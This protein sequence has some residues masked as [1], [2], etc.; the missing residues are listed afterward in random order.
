MLRIRVGGLTILGAPRVNEPAVGLFVGPDGFQ[1]WDDST[2]GR[3]DSTDRPS[4]H[5]S[6]DGPLLRGER[7]FSVDGHAIAASA[8][9]LGHLRSRVTGLGGDG[10]RVRVTVDH[11]GQTLWAD[12]KVPEATF[13]DLGFRGR[14]HRARFSLQFVAAD[15]RK[16]GPVQSFPGAS[17]QAFHYGNFPAAPVIDVVG[18]VAAPY[19]VASQ[20]KSYT[21][22]QALTA[23]QTHRIDMSTGW[24]TRN[25]VLQVGVV[26][27]AQTFEIPPGLPVT[28][29]GPASMTVKVTDTYI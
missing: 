9:E 18:P 29:T 24:V 22:T 15:M 23:G 8:A 17:V 21:V 11:Q 1:G 3:R 27:S 5:G 25:G 13:R 4:A 20:G 16:Y 2:T 26:S 7:V 12:A 19:T 14:R 28:V 10:A 6:F